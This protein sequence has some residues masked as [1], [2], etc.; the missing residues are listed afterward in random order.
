[1]GV[2]CRGYRALWLTDIDKTLLPMT[3]DRNP[4]H[5]HILGVFFRELE[6]H[7]VLVVPV[8]F[9]TRSELDYLS[10]VIGYR[11]SVYVAEGGC[12]V[13]LGGEVIELCRG[14]G[15]ISRVLDEF[16]DDDCIDSIVRLSRLSVEDA[17]RIL[18]L[19]VDE[20]RYALD[21]KYTEIV[22]SQSSTCIDRVAKYV[23]SRG[24][25][26]IR[27]RRFLHVTDAYKEDG[28]RVLLNRLLYR[29]IGPVIASGDNVFDRGF[30][31][32]ADIAIVVSSDGYE[33]FRRYPYIA[34]HGDI[35]E[36]L[37]DVVS[38]ILLYRSFR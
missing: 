24:L 22:Y 38:R 7:C 14:L 20:A 15:H 32:L 34:V 18:Q 27:S 11:F 6:E 23:E 28:V 21:R 4:V 9:K 17:N 13:S 31:E 5:L 35:P 8:T 36:A 30:M 12:E 1:M 37:I 3:T 29:V 16:S 26:A 25:K 19:P 2:G 10:R 33:W